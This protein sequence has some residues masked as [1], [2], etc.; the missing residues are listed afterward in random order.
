M[1]IGIVGTP[2]YLNQPG[3]TN[4]TVT[5]PVTVP[6]GAELL[7]IKIASKEPDWIDF[8]SLTVNGTSVGVVLQVTSA[9]AANRGCRIWTVVNPTPGTYN[10]VAT[11]TTSSGNGGPYIAECWAGGVDTTTPVSAVN[12]SSSTSS[13]GG[14]STSI[15]VNSGGVA[16]GVTY[17][18]TAQPTAV[19]GQTVTGIEESFHTSSY[20]ANATAYAVTYTGT[21]QAANAVIAINP[22]AAPITAAIGWTEANDT[23]V[24]NGQI[25]VTAAAA[26]TEAN[27]TPAI[28]V[29]V[30]APSVTIAAAWTEANDTVAITGTVTNPTLTTRIFRNNT[31]T[32]R[33]NLA[34]CTLNIYNAT[35]GV[36][37]LHLTGLTTTAAGRLVVSNAALAFGVPVTYEADFSA[38]GF[39]RRLPTGTPT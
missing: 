2:A 4:A 39:G 24:I 31:G 28:A 18:D 1:S 33:V 3:F 5:L 26:W 6:S 37:I 12:S 11:W 23:V 13:T 32:P 38:A 30:G 19:A 34:N 16:T 25:S 7:V 22:A 14:L 29:T 35:S 15:S 36:L 20:K 10:I 9:N 8:T 21:P 17:T 27:D